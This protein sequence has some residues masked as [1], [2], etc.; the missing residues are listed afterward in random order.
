[1]NSR[2]ASTRYVA[3]RRRALTHVVTL[4]FLAAAL[5]C[6]LAASARPAPTETPTRDP[7]LDCGDGVCGE[8]EDAE[9]CPTD[10]AEATEEPTP[11]PPLVRTTAEISIYSGPDEACEELDTYENG[12]EVEVLAKDPTGL[13]WQVPHG[14]SVGWLS[15][16][17]TT[18]VSDLSGVQEIPGPSCASSA[19]ASGAA[20]SS[21]APSS[22]A[23]PTSEPPTS[24]PPSGNAQPPPAA[25]VCGNGV[26]EAGEACD[27]SDGPCGNGQTCGSGCQCETT[28]PPQPASVCGNGTIEAGEE[29]DSSHDGCGISETCND[30][31]QCEFHQIHLPLPV[32][33]N[34]IIEAGEECDTTNTCGV[35]AVCKSNCECYSV[36]I[37]CGD[38]KLD[39][40]EE[41]DG[42]NASCG[43]GRVCNNNCLCVGI[44]LP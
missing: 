33:G 5:A 8:G 22:G 40:G 3:V 41:C 11:Q 18:P 19:S 44:H 12:T 2:T 25:P 20:P 34:G 38:G 39:P 29:C 1:M 9:S 27:G 21:N 4:T 17:Y 16:A 7:A 28:Q 24:E 37:T 15:A 35:F 23:P 32:C 43:S 6:N 13:W 42:S 26:V 14:D 30:N 10:C 36:P 31:C